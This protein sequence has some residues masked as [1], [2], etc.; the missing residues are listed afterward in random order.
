MGKIVDSK[1]HSSTRRQLFFRGRLSEDPRATRRGIAKHAMRQVGKGPR[2]G[3]QAG[4]AV[5]VIGND[6]LETFFL[7]SG[8]PTFAIMA[9]EQSTRGI[10]R[11]DL[12]L[13]RASG[14]RRRT[15]L[16][17]LMDAGFRAW[18]IR[19]KLFGPFL[20]RPCMKRG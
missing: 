2:R 7:T 3:F 14:H 11:K 19:K 5:I 10:R 12:R 17:K 18:R 15:A 9:G 4:H 13:A 16:H 8:P 1:R 6:H 20:M